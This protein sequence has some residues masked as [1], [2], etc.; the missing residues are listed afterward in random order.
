M[1]RKAFLYSAALASLLF[2]AALTGCGSDNKEG[3][4]SPA[5][6]PKVSEAAC[7]QC[8]GS[9]VSSV[10]GLSIYDGYNKSSHLANGCQSCHGGG[11]Q[12]NGVGP[13]PY[14]KP[15]RAGQCLTCHNEGN[16]P[17]H[18][19]AHSVVISTGTVVSATFTSERTQCTFCHDPHAT[20]PARTE[21]SV[22]TQFA[23]SGHGDVNADPWVHYDFGAPDRAACA[24]CHTATGYKM[25]LE[26]PK[27][28][29]W[30]YKAADN[31]REVLRCDACHTSYSYARRD[32]ATNG[33]GAAMLAYST[34]VPSGA[35]VNNRLGDAKESN[36]CTN[37][38]TGRAS[39]TG[40]LRGTFKQFSS[41][42]FAFNS[43]YMAAGGIMYGIVGFENFSTTGLSTSHNKYV[44]VGFGHAGIG[45]DNGKGPCVGCHFTANGGLLPLTTSGTAPS[46]HDLKA[47]NADDTLKAQC[48]T[49]HGGAGLTIDIATA[50]AQFQSALTL[51]K[52]LLST[53][54]NIMY[55]SAA[56]PYFF[57]LLVADSSN[58]VGYSTTIPWNGRATAGGDVR[59]S[60]TPGSG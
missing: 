8:H 19:A 34:T 39:G 38:H 44:P 24:R 36:L 3:G 15:D 12:H 23:D 22:F 58:I 32:G 33:F 20:E 7:A 31:N 27:A 60:Y 18:F 51:A 2:T 26:S 37:C 57:N 59:K 48:N 46:S 14:P 40:I 47:I 4:I 30:S 6:V 25:Y 35:L 11:A 5:D 56:N 41:S 55:S 50:R 10:T 53:R 52:T 45:L 16:A 21:G 17:N 49:C 9:A 54:Y 43:H 13:L 1:S 28:G 42:S 29:G